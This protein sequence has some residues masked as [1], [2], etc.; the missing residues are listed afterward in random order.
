MARKRKISTEELAR[1]VEQYFNEEAQKLETKADFP[2]FNEQEVFEK[3]KRR[4]FVKKESEKRELRVFSRKHMWAKSLIGVAAL[5]ILVISI[6]LAVGRK[7]YSDIPKIDMVEIKTANG[8][9]KTITLKDGSVMILNAASVAH[10][11]SDFGKTTRSIWLEG[12]AFFEVEKNDQLPFFVYSSSSKTQVLGTSFNVS[13]YP[14]DNKMCIT[15]ASGRVKV[16]AMDAAKRNNAYI[17]QPNQMIVFDKRD[18]KYTMQKVNAQH[19][20]GWINNKLHFEK[21]T[22]SEIVSVLNRFYNISI[23]LEGTA[24]HACR[25]TVDFNNIPSNT[26]AKILADLSAASLIQQKGQQYILKLN[27]C[28][29]P[30]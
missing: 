23:V 10:I 13:A 1:L 3:I 30:M 12:E 21:K 7:T 24:Q 6:W 16:D 8:K 17:L 22:V 14:Q 29:V 18:K 9:R 27:Q 5:C 2:D 4:T 20:K 28:K 25:Y 19:V 26:A 11:P 15:V